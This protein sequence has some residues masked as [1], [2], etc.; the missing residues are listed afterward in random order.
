MDLEGI[1]ELQGVVF[2]NDEDA[3][4]QVAAR[5]GITSPLDM[6]THVHWTLDFEL[7]ILSE[8]HPSISAIC[9]YLHQCRYP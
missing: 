5:P 1:P 2:P 7:W 3:G 4:V 9:S 6:E 8:R